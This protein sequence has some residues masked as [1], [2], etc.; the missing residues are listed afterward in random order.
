MSPFQSRTLD[1]E[2]PA[3]IG[4]HGFLVLEPDSPGDF[5]GDPLMT[6]LYNGIIGATLGGFEVKGILKMIPDQVADIAAIREANDP[7]RYKGPGNGD[8]YKYGWETTVVRVNP[9]P[10]MTDTVFIKLLETMA[11][12]YNSNNAAF[13]QPFK[14]GPDAAA[15]NCQAWVN[16][17]L[18][19]AGVPAGQLA[20]I[21]ANI[22]SNSPGVVWG[23][24]NVLPG[25]LFAI[26]PQLP[27]PAA[28]R[29]K[30]IDA[31]VAA[32]MKR[33]EQLGGAYTPAQ[34]SQTEAYLRK[35]AEEIY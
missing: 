23:A 7:T 15:T 5:A 22:Y 28:V 1:T 17:I 31:Y 3:A 35:K 29:Q 33:L 26:P 25:S 14:L 16:S 21:Q 8:V 9:P 24:R 12:A 11:S 34:R 18:T 27:N 4:R 32:T 19:F 10:G 30:Q 20:A 6:D 2:T 13:Q